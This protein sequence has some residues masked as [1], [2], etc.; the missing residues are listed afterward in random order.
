M[1]HQPKENTNFITIYLTYSPNPQSVLDPWLSTGAEINY[2]FLKFFFVFFHFFIYF[3]FPC[4]RSKW[5]I[6]R[7]NIHSVSSNKLIDS[8][9]LIKLFVQVWWLIQIT[10]IND[11]RPI[12]SVSNQLRKSVANISSWWL[13]TQNS[14]LLTT[15]ND[16]ST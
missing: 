16:H 15:Q 7:Q 5:R 6:S 14:D 12:D 1:C 10:A 4:D 3:N 11:R 9:K 2:N 8:S 13:A